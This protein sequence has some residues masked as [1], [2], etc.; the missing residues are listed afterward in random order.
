MKAK[1]LS[2]LETAMYRAMWE[3]KY[4]SVASNAKVRINLVGLESK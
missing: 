2:T 3:R 1:L 4:L